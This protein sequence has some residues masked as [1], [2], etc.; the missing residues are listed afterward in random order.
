MLEIHVFFQRIAFSHPPDH[1]SAIQEMPLPKS[2]REL[3][4]EVGLFNWFKKYIDNFS[5]T[6]EPLARLLRKNMRFRWTS[7]QE[8]VLLP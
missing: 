7:E 2:V 4:H 1:V 6:I 8:S 3:R 5:V